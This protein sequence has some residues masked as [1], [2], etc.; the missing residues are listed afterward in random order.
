METSV[1]LLQ[2]IKSQGSDE[3][4]ALLESIYAPMIRK[5]SRKAGISRADEDDLVQEIFLQ[6]VKKIGTFERGEYAGSFRRWLKQITINCF[7]N[8]IRLRGNRALGFG[9]S[10]V[11]DFLAQYADPDSDLSRIWNEEHEKAV[12][13]HLLSLVRPGF[14]QATWQ[15]FYQTAVKSR[16]AKEVAAELHMTVGAVHTARSR[17]LAEMRRIG[18]GMLNDSSD[19]NVTE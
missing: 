18:Q 1:T 11:M 12:I 10:A 15:A 9:G 5:W 4:W 14:K 17:V 19:L 16:Q 6:V 13:K 2:T 3:S 7:R 8:Y